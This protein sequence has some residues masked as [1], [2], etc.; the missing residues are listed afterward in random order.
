MPG[1]SAVQASALSMDATRESAGMA[2]P[3][4]RRSTRTTVV[5]IAA[6]DHGGVRTRVRVINLS[7]HGALVK[8]DGLPATGDVVFLSNGVAVQSKVAWARGRHSGIQF[9]DP[10]EPECFLRNA[11]HPHPVITKDNRNVDFR[12]PGFRG[13]LLNSEEKRVVDNWNCDRS[14]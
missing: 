11:R 13:N 8:G 7:A 3:D 14:S 4:D 5:L 2:D 6:I 1:R 10:I 9:Q 12:R